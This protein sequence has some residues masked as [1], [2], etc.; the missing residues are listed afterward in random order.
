MQPYATNY[1][2][3]QLF[4]NSHGSGSEEWTE[5]CENLPKIEVHAPHLCLGIS[6]VKCVLFIFFLKSNFW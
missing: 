3:Y 4:L 1:C 2:A 5:F 6:I